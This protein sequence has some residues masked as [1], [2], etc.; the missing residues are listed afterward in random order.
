MSPTD[1]PNG[2]HRGAKPEASP[3]HRLYLL[4]SLAAARR[5]GV[6][7]AG[8]CALA[9]ALALALGLSAGP[10]NAGRSCEAQ[11]PTIERVRQGL[12]LAE[13]TARALDASGAQVVLLARAGQDLSAWNLRWSHLALAYRSRAEPNQP[14]AWRV[15]HKLNHCDSADA[16]LYRQGLAEF[17]LDDPHRFE[18]ALLPID[19]GL[20]ARLEALLHHDVLVRVMDEARYSMLSYPWAQ[21]YQQSNQWVIETLAVV[22]DPA[23]RTRRQAQAWLQLK[24][25][26]GTVLRLGPFTRLGARMT[27]ANI[28]FDDHPDHLRFADR[29][30]TVSA[31]SVLDWLPRVGLGGPLQVVR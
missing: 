2:E 7:R 10:A 29:I 20:A 4:L 12:A 30:E 13:A 22:A 15:V 16:A 23:V 5:L 6:R 3:R 9:L 14:A 25:Y 1:R 11:P 18:A 31:D 27:R 26:Q 8:S 17:F 21:T 24:G 19:A 28:A